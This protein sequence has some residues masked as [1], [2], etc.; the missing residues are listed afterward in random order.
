MIRALKEKDRGKNE[1]AYLPNQISYCVLGNRCKNGGIMKV[2]E[3]G[4]FKCL[5]PPK[6]GGPLCEGN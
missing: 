3:N 6:Y 4:L 5:C 2:C 1:W